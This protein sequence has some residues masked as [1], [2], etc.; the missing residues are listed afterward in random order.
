MGAAGGITAAL[1]ACSGRRP[2]ASSLVPT[3]AVGVEVES[4]LLLAWGIGLSLPAL[5]YLYRDRDK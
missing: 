1:V 2:D 3:P 4:C 5:F